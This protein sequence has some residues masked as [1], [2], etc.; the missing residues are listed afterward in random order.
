M[1]E[2]HVEMW[3]S[4]QLFVFCFIYQGASVCLISQLWGRSGGVCLSVCQKVAGIATPLRHLLQSDT[5]P[6]VRSI[7]LCLHP[8]SQREQEIVNY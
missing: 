5:S 3:S 6:S 7:C 4:R 2:Y 8:R 1:K